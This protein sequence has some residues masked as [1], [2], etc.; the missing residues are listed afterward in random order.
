[1]VLSTTV[2][3]KIWISLSTIPRF[4]GL[5]VYS[6]DNKFVTELINWNLLGVIYL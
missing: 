3:I 5:K 6:L 2:P 1:M 4:F